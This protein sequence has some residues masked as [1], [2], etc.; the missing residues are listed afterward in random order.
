M[1]QYAFFMK[2]KGYRHKKTAKNPFFPRFLSQTLVEIVT[3][4][5]N[6]TNSF[7]SCMHP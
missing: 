2:L 7:F 5:S 4:L 1:Q 6:L 3:K